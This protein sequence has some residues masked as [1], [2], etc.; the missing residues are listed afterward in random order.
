MNSKRF[1]V[2]L[3]AFAA[4]MGAIALTNQGVRDALAQERTDRPAVEPGD[5]I[6]VETEREYERET[7]VRSKDRIKHKDALKASEIIG[8]NVRAKSGNENI[9]SINDLMLHR[10][11]KVNYVAVSFGDFLGIGDKLFAVPFEA[12]E[13]VRG[14]D[15]SFAR[16]DVTE[17]TLKQREGFNQDNWPAMADKSFLGAERQVERRVTDEPLR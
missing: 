15:A 7:S 17:D 8:M 3:A 9:G 14:E 13:F 6:E 16:I 2:G 4:V 10:D 5:R 1:Y 12:I 11:G